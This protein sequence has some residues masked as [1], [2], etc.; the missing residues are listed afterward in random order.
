MHRFFPALMLLH[1][2]VI[3]EEGN[4]PTRTTREMKN[5]YPEPSQKSRM[6]VFRVC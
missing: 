5:V 2:T 4:L 1:T 3:F 6:S